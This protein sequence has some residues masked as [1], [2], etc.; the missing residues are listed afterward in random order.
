M[1]L[2]Y[3]YTD[4]YLLRKT[5]QH[6]QEYTFNDTK[7]VNIDLSVYLGVFMGLYLPVCF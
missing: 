5:Q 3:R 7:C 1:Y 4:T 2:L 6:T